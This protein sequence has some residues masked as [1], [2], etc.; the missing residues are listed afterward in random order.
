VNKQLK[1]LFT[2]LVPGCKK[3]HYQFDITDLSK[4]LVLGFTNGEKET[5]NNNNNKVE[6]E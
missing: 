2:D 1:I 6:N 3:C 5:I 4:Y